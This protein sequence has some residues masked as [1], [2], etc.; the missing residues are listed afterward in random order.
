MKSLIH[1]L[2]ETEY[3]EKRNTATQFLSSNHIPLHIESDGSYCSSTGNP[4]SNFFICPKRVLHPYSTDRTTTTLVFQFEILNDRQ[5]FLITA[6]SKEIHSMKW[7]TDLESN[8]Y[9]N[10]RYKNYDVIR[11]IFSAMIHTDNDTSV[12]FDGTG[13]Y[14]NNGKWSYSASNLT[15]YPDYLDWNPTVLLPECNDCKTHTTCAECHYRLNSSLDD[16]SKPE[17]SQIEYIIET[18][19]LELCK[20]PEVALPIFLMNL[21]SSTASIFSKVGLFTPIILW[22]TGE[23]GAG[24]TQLALYIGSFYNHSNQRDDSKL[25]KNFL[26]ANSKTTILQAYLHNNRDNTIILDDVKTDK[27]MSLREHTITNIDILIRTI[28]DHN[29]GQMPVYSNAIITGEYIP[30]MKSTLSRIVVL[31]IKSF[32]DAPENL[33]TLSFFQDN[34]YLITDFTVLFIQ[35]VCKKMNEDMFLNSLHRKKEQYLEKYYKEK[36]FSARSSESL[37]TLRLGL[38]LLQDFCYEKIK[39]TVDFREKLNELAKS[40]ILCFEKLVKQT[41]YLSESHERIY[42]EILSRLI[43][44]KKK[45]RSVPEITYED[46]LNL[47]NYCISASETG[48]YIENPAVLS[49]RPYF[50]DASNCTPC[51]LIRADLIDELRYEVENYCE[52]HDIPIQNTNKSTAKTL[53]NWGFILVDIYRNDANINSIVKYPAIDLDLATK[54][55][56]ECYLDSVYRINL[57]HPLLKDMQKALRNMKKEILNVVH[58]VQADYNGENLGYSS[59]DNRNKHNYHTMKQHYNLDCVQSQFENIFH[60]RHTKSKR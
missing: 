58:E 10:N 8:F 48:I 55:K 15:I 31:P 34:G 9:L 41:S 5:C 47:F 21:L 2:N 14:C 53:T 22:L 12:F 4:I 17:A 3:T 36:S 35:W 27:S 60:Y 57:N 52:N 37:I 54:R 1:I 51:L 59:A 18:T 24:K 38:D 25:I 49:N 13:L 23:P 11:Q 39:V 46:T 30:N 26:R 28:Y 16:I 42:A 44:H 29:L 19:V 32:K 43:L 6:S 50:K 45:I 40:G 33:N 56:N 20:N 7:I